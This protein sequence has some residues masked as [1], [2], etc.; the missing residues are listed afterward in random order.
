MKCACGDSGGA[1]RHREARADGDAALI[2]GE[3]SHSLSRRIAVYIC[4][5]LVAF[6]MTT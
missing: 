2:L 6:V 1:R 5:K 4:G 3:L